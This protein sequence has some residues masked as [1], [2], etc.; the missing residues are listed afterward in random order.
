[1]TAKQRNEFLVTDVRTVRTLEFTEADSVAANELGILVGVS[2]ACVSMVKN[3]QWKWG[4]PSAV[5]VPEQDLFSNQTV[6][7]AA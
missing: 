5:P 1:M 3:G 2:Q 4:K 7:E 6:G